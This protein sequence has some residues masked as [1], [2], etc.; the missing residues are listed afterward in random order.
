[1]SKLSNE[2][3]KIFS[4]SSNNKSSEKPPKPYWEIDWSK[5]IALI[6]GNEGQGIHKKIQQAFDETITIPHS[7]LVESLNV[8]CV[9]VPLLLERKR[10]AYTSNT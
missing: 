9:A 5:S 7:E 10:V 2:G 1:M 4:T 6:L 3:F 8:A